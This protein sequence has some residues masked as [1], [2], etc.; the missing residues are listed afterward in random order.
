MVRNSYQTAII[1]LSFTGVYH[2]DPRV[3]SRAILPNFWRRA[4]CAF[5]LQR[6]KDRPRAFFSH[7]YG[8]LSGELAFDA[9]TATEVLPVMNAGRR[10]AVMSRGS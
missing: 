2:D 7:Q 6:G 5:Y 10:E 3:K 1:V 4:G 9:M 8:Y